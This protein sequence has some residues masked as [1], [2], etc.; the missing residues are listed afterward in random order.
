MSISPFSQRHKPD[1]TYIPA[2]LMDG[3]YYRDSSQA[4]KVWIERRQWSRARTWAMSQP[5]K[6][7]PYSWPSPAYYV[8]RSREYLRFKHRVAVHFERKLA[9]MRHLLTY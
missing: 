9:A 1:V 5:L 2:I 8:Y 3:R 7:S 4:A 6:T